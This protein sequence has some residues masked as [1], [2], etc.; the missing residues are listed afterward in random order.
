MD[1]RG[2]AKILIIVI[3]VLVLLIVIGGAAAVYFLFFRSGEE[4]PIEKRP[5]P[6]IVHQLRK[7]SNFRVNVAESNYSVFLLASVSLGYS[8]KKLGKEL[9]SR[10]VQIE[11]IVESVLSSWTLEEFAEDAERSNLKKEIVEK[12][13]VVLKKGEIEDVYITEFIIQ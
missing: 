1:N 4:S 5:D 10:Q 8:E 6:M 2:F 9:V 7:G 11:D 3:I 13:N 12:V